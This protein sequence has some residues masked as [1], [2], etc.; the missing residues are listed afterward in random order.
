MHKCS[1][2]DLIVS[3][4]VE[5]DTFLNQHAF[6]TGGNCPYLQANYTSDRLVIEIRQERARQ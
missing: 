6:F 4:F 5:G 2:C 3:N 1:S